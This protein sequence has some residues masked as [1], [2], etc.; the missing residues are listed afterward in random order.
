LAAPYARRTRRSEEEKSATR[1]GA[2][3]PLLIAGE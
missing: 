2:W 3:T 1:I